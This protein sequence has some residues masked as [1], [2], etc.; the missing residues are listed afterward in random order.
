MPSEIDKKLAELKA[1]DQELENLKSELKQNN[2]KSI[3]NLRSLLKEIG[4]AAPEKEKQIALL[5]KLAEKSNIG[6]A[7]EVAKKLNDPQLLD[8]FHD[9]IV[10]HFEELKNKLKLKHL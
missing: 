2:K 10:N 7:V 3:K 6:Y 9:E 1:K 4:D 5:I 8:K